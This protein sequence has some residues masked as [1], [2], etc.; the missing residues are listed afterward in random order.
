MLCMFAE[1]NVTWV[2]QLYYISNFVASFPRLLYSVLN[3]YSWVKVI[4]AAKICHSEIQVELSYYVLRRTTTVESIS[5]KGGASWTITGIRSLLINT[6][7]RTKV[8]WIL[9][10]FIDVC[11]KRL[12]M[13]HD[14]RV[15]PK[16][17]NLY[18]LP[19]SHCDLKLKTTKSVDK[20]YSVCLITLY[21]KCSIP[22]YIPCT[23]LLSPEQS[24]Y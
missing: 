11:N 16:W 5:S 19:L 23:T 8:L 13:K 18:K 12:Q 10:A 21:I 6:P 24:N 20:H 4:S 2:A 7:I 22:C 3:W 9:Q 1:W 17:T 14:S 15:E